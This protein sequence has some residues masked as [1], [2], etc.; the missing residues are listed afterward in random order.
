M[1]SVSI[2]VY[3]KFYTSPFEFIPFIRRVI[4]FIMYCI[5]QFLRVVILKDDV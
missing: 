3:I 1:K 2:E 4:Q 5:F